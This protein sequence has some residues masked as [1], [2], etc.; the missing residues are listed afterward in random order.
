MLIAQSNIFSSI[1][2]Y[3]FWLC[4]SYIGSKDFPAVLGVQTQDIC[5]PNAHSLQDES[6]TGACV[7]RSFIPTLYSFQGCLFYHHSWL[8]QEDRFWKVILLIF[9]KDRSYFFGYQ[10][11]R[12]VRVQGSLIMNGRVL[13]FFQESRTFFSGRLPGTCTLFHR[14]WWSFIALGYLWPKAIA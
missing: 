4:C 6:G 7:L 2:T 11:Q 1:H 5:C 9:A 13:S 12:Q 8:S 14:L 3:R 10:S